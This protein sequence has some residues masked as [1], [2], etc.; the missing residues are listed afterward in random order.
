MFEFFNA[1]NK[2]RFRKVRTAYLNLI[3]FSLD[4]Y[5]HGQVIRHNQFN[6]VFFEYDKLPKFSSMEMFVRLCNKRKLKDMTLDFMENAWE[7]VE[8]EEMTLKYIQAYRLSWRTCK[9]S[10]ELKLYTEAGICV[11]DDND[12]LTVRQMRRLLS[13]SPEEREGI[14]QAFREDTQFCFNQQIDIEY[15]SK[16]ETE[17]A[18]EEKWWRVNIAERMDFLGF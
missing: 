9:F 11:H 2:S 10:G 8:K 3:G 18:A 7:Q 6:G 14:L 5:R 12:F 13:I 15:K 16:L 17:Y 4:N 1:P